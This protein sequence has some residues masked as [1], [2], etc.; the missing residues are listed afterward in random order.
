[1]LTPKSI[2]A[3]ILLFIVNFANAQE[4]H[5][6]SVVPITIDQLLTKP[7]DKY[8][9]LS[10]P[11]APCTPA[12]NDNYANAI[13]LSVGAAAINGRSCGAL[14]TGEA[15]GCNSTATQS[16]WYLVTATAGF[17]YVII[18]ATGSS[19]YTGAAI[20]PATG[21]P[22]SNCSMIDCQSA[23]N[24]PTVT[25]FK[26]EGAIGITYAIQITYTPNAFCGKEGTF[27]IRAANSYGSTIS[28]PGAINTC[29]TAYNGCYFTSTP[30]SAQITS[31]CASYP[32]VTQANLVN[33]A[34]YKFTTAPINSNV[35][36]FQ[37]LLS[38]TCGGGN[39]SW[40]TYRLYDQYCNLLACG[41]LGNLQNNVACNQPYVL[42]YS[43]EEISG[44]TYS[45]HQPYQ[46]VPTGTVGCG[47]PLPIE[48]VKFEAKVID[49]KSQIKWAT[50]KESNN[51][52]FQIER[53]VN[54][55][56]FESVGKI[57]G[58]GNTNSF[59][60]YNFEDA[61]PENGRFYYRLKQVDYN[62][63]F[64]YSKVISVAS[65][66]ESVVLNFKNPASENVDMVLEND[67]SCQAK[68]SYINSQGVVCESEQWDLIKGVNK[69]TYSLNN[70]KP[71]IYTVIITSE[72]FTCHQKLVK[73]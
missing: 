60:Q 28:N 37:D 61:L 47:T 42:E 24:G 66:A 70:L 12:A 69:K 71:G 38:S 34:F 8:D 13:T 16:V 59:S 35:L 23:A 41:D 56:N 72:F 6:I 43:W 30:T 73:V 33:K 9:T 46:Y 31:G 4:F 10:M 21:L 25:V 67:I 57:A 68:I 32:L 52:Y 17:T 62:G 15:K 40:F 20:W 63:D 48:L 1:M 3:I 54:N 44:C 49:K 58:R 7:I 45:Q 50:T 27:T 11:D 5:S 51:D 14:Q 22:T 64:K 39:V 53:S 26:L 29:A 55:M 19:C 65:F 2:F 36:N 18:D